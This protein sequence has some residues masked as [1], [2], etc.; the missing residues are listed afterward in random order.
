MPMVGRSH[1]RGYYKAERVGDCM[2]N[3]CRLTETVC[4]RSCAKLQ[5]GAFQEKRPPQ[6]KTNE[7]VGI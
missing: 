4:R 5:S 6:V 2:Q 3:G 1:E 7:S